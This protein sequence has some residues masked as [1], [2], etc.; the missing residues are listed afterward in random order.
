MTVAGK[1]APKLILKSHVEAMKR[2]FGLPIYSAATDIH[3]P[4][5]ML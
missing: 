4:H 1:P 2:E 3:G 5:L